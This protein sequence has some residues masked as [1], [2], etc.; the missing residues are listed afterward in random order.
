MLQNGWCGPF[1]PGRSEPAQVP[2]VSAPEVSETRFLASSKSTPR[3]LRAR[4][5]AVLPE[6]ASEPSRSTVAGA[7]LPRYTPV[8]PISERYAKIQVAYQG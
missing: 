4:S 1:A 8:S 3:A 2:T 5:D 7:C 6:I